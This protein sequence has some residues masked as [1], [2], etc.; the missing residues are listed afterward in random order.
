MSTQIGVIALVGYVDREYEMVPTQ[1][2]FIFYLPIFW[3]EN[4]D[5]FK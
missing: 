3:Y 5:L 2:R 1:V 4:V